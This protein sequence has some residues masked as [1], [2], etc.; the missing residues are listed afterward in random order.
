V[1]PPTPIGAASAAAP[2]ATRRRLGARWLVALLGVIV[3][4]G[5]S[6]V[7]VSLAAG[8]P[9]PSNGAL[10]GIP[11]TV[12]SSYSVSRSAPRAAAPAVMS[13]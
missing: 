12:A 1:I 8:R 13:S 6:A 5:G 11:A 3:V 4:I 9:A 10:E 7:V 2:V